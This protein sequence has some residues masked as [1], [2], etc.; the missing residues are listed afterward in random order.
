MFAIPTEG[1]KAREL[2]GD[3]S[4]VAELLHPD[5][6]HKLPSFG[7]ALRKGRRYMAEAGKS[8]ASRVVFVCYGNCN[9]P[10]QYGRIILLSVG[11]R[12]GFRKE[13]TFGPIGA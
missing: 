5:N 4:H 8:G 3:I 9:V 11:R 13:W 6:R 12:G 7:E 2:M 1:T 10:S